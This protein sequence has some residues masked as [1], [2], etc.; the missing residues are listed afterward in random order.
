[1][2]KI[3]TDLFEKFNQDLI[4]Y[5]V[6]KSI[7]RVGPDTNGEAE[8]VDLLISTK[9][10]KKSE[11]ILSNLGFKKILSPGEYD[12]LGFYIGYDP[13]TRKQ[14]LIHIHNKLRI[15]HKLY[16]QF[17]LK[18]EHEILQNRIFNEEYRVYTTS[19]DLEFCILL[20]RMI[21]RT[22]YKVEDIARLNFLSKRIKKTDS[23][24]L[25]I[26]SEMF[27]NSID[28]F[29]S[30]TYNPLTLLSLNHKYGP[31]TKRY[32]SRTF[33]EK[34][35]ILSRVIDGN[36]KLIIKTLC[37][38]YKFPK[39]R[40]RRYGKLVAFQGVDGSG[41]STQVNLLLETKYLQ[42]T[43][44]KR[45]YGGNNEYWIPGLTTISQKLSTKRDN[46][47]NFLKSILSVLTIIDR[48]L[49]MIPALINI[50]KGK[51]VIF[52][53]YFYDDLSY[54]PKMKTDKKKSS[55]IKRTV[56]KIFMSKL[57]YTPHLT[58]FLDINTEDAYKRKQ[59]Y[60]F[61]KVNIQIDA[62]RDILINRKEVTTINACNSI[63]HINQEIIELINNL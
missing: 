31:R 56:K 37:S 63:D 12:G 60:S 36:K 35:L 44:I 62:Y 25:S 57:G 39:Y 54:I 53:R 18:L 38:L 4:Q 43:G 7:E 51:I 22:R 34:C 61:E 50:I 59:D 20:T 30:I 5:V 21:L 9:S 23:I 11:T 3:C 15:G 42:I 2:L 45:I 17:H 8:D 58:I 14:I 55:L 28:Y 10:K 24:A 16:K 40:I 47:S 33:L 27:G 1:M 46:F 52:D 41:K 49:R 29:T 32:L 48:R 6:V 13:Q 19:P 26:I